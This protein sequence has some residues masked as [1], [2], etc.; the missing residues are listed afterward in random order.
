MKYN[1]IITDLATITSEYNLIFLRNFNPSYSLKIKKCITENIRSLTT[2][3][4]S[5][6][7]YKNINNCIYRKL[8]INNLYHIIFTVKENCVFVF[9]VNDARRAYDVYLPYLK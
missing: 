8:I 1:V 2:F 6:A 3:P 5:H 4:H 7:I 9:Y